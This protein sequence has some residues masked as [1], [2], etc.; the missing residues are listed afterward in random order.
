MDRKIVGIIANGTK[1]AAAALLGRVVKKLTE[2]GREVLLED[3][4]ASLL[5][6]V[7]DYS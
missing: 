1:P 5:G 2:L 4:S 3:S 7:S 6:Q